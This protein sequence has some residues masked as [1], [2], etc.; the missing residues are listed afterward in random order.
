LGPDT[1]SQRG[2]GVPPGR[3]SRLRLGGS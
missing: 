1:L 2:F 3:I